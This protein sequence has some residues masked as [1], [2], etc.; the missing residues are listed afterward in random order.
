LKTSYGA[1][2][3]TATFNIFQTDPNGNCSSGNGGLNGN[4]NSIISQSGNVQL[5]FMDGTY[6]S[7]G[8]VSYSSPSASSTTWGHY[9]YTVSLGQVTFTNTQRL[10]F[11]TKFVTQTYGQLGMKMIIDNT[12]L[13]DQYGQSLLQTP[14]PTDP[15]MGYYLYLANSCSG[16]SGYDQDGNVYVYNAGPD[17]AWVQQGSRAI[18]TTSDKTSAYAGWIFFSNGF[19][20]SASRTDSVVAQVGASTLLYYSTPYTQPG[21]DGYQQG[22]RVPAGNYLL[23][24]YLFGYDQEGHSLL[25]T[26]YIGP[27]RV[28]YTNTC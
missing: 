26:D 9:N 8:S 22:T 4:C 5:P 6:T 15:F 14:S 23:Y 11:Q 10:E 24:I 27:V 3:E 1:N 17:L 18:F 2:A 16:N 7:G 25:S 20:S 19:H 12:G 28:Y 13:S 21:L